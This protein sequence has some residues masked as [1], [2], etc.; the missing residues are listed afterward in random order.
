M[1]ADEVKSVA[2]ALRENN[3]EVVSVQTTKFRS[4]YTTLPTLTRVA[5]K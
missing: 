1:L 5:V 4:P 2:Q 3:V